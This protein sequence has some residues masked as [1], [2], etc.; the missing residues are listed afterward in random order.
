MSVV[1]MVLKTPWSFCF[2]IKELMA[3]GTALMNTTI[4]DVTGKFK[5][6]IVNMRMIWLGFLME[7]KYFKLS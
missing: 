6:L 2:G 1:T 7:K 3:F 4:Q 5:K